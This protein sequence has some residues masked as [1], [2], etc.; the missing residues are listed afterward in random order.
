[1]NCNSVENCGINR[2]GR[3]EAPILNNQGDLMG[4]INR[5]DIAIKN[6]RIA[7]L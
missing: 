7:T 1:M 5:T 3:S 6:Y 4:V 2:V